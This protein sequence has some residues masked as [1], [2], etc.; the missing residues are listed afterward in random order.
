MF[1]ELG[2]QLAPLLV[3]RLFT[4]R[5]GRL[6]LPAIDRPNIRTR[7]VS[8]YPAPYWGHAASLFDIP[9]RNAPNFERRDPMASSKFCHS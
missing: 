9:E 1:F 4:N 7:T 5:S 2:A 3:A 6:I 8:Y